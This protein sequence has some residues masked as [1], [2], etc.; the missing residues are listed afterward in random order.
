MTSDNTIAHAGRTT[1]VPIALQSEPDP[2]VSFANTI[3]EFNMQT[4]VQ[5]IEHHE[6][7]R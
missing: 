6:N 5:A 3:I 7:I 1:K 4:Q 2:E